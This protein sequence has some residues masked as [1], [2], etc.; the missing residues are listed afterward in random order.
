MEK[1]LDSTAFNKSGLRYSFQWQEQVHA[2]RM[3]SLLDEVYAQSKHIH[4]WVL[5][6]WWKLIID[7]AVLASKLYHVQDRLM[8]HNFFSFH[9]SK[10]SRD[11]KWRFMTTLRTTFSNTPSSSLC[12]HTGNFPSLHNSSIRNH[13]QLHLWSPTMFPTPHFEWSKEKKASCVGQ[14]QRVKLHVTQNSCH[15]ISRCLFGSSFH[16]FGTVMLGKGMSL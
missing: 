6:N 4:L 7:A 3:E 15:W 10:N 1:Q 14:P 2:C 5:N 13:C 8:W 11:T 16:F 9:S 12:Y